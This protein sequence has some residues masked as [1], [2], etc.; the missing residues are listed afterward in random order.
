MYPLILPLLVS[1]PKSFLILLLLTGLVLNSSVL[2]KVE[3]YSGYNGK[4]VDTVTTIVE[5][6]IWDSASYCVTFQIQR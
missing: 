1:M 4:S 5:E 2:L 3:L 6:W